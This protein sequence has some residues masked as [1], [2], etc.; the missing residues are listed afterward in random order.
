MEL[1]LLEFRGIFFRREEGGAYLYLKETEERSFIVFLYLGFI[2][3]PQLIIFIR[4]FKEIFT[5]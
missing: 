2:R 4:F 1:Y 5:G 3:L